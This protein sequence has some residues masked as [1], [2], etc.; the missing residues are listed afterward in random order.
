MPNARIT[1]AELQ[2]WRT[3][4]ASALRLMDEVEVLL[5]ERSDARRAFAGEAAAALEK[6]LREVEAYN[7]GGCQACHEAEAR[8][9]LAKLQKVAKG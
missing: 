6:R 2:R 8:A 1:P 5:R 4:L 7:L 3:L 9:F